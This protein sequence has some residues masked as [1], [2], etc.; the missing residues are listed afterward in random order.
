MSLRDNLGPVKC[1]PSADAT[2][3]EWSLSVLDSRYTLDLCH[4]PSKTSDISC[5]VLRLLNS[6]ISDMSRKHELE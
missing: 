6:A 5:M 2:S 1:L 3:S 4:W